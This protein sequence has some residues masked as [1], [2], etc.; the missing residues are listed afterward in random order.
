MAWG[1]GIAR[2]ASPAP[3]APLGDRGRLWLPLPAWPLP[4]VLGWAE[5]S[6]VLR[7]GVTVLTTP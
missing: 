7:A 6:P 4:A 5:E 1:G 3:E 2:T